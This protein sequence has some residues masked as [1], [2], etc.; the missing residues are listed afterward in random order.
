MVVAV[1][2]LSPFIGD[3]TETNRTVNGIDC[4]FMECDT[5]K[6]NAF[7]K[8]T[9]SAVSVEGYVFDDMLKEEII[10]LRS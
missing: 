5:K 10:K 6:K 2:G 1:S 8:N 3:F 7:I 4:P 9:H